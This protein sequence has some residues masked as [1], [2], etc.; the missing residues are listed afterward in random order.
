[1][2]VKALELSS[3]A[4]D[5]GVTPVSEVED[6]GV[7]DA[8]QAVKRQAEAKRGSKCFIARL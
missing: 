4:E 7:G 1:M 2:R 5:M 3:F 6:D 8:A